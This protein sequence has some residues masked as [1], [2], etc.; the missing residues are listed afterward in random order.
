MKPQEKYKT[1]QI[2]DLTFTANTGLRLPPNLSLLATMNTSDQ[3]V[4]TLDN[5][6]QRRWEMELV[7]NKFGTGDEGENQKNAKIEGTKITWE[8]FQT[9]IN[10]LISDLSKDSG[11]SSMVDKRLGCWFV[12]AEEVNGEFIITQETF[13][14]KILKYLWDD[15]FKFNRDVFSDKN[16]D[17]FG[18]FEKLLEKVDF[19]KENFDVFKDIKFETDDTTVISLDTAVT[20]SEQ[21]V[22]SS[23]VEP[24]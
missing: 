18:D 4:F 21:N 24:I 7:E 5:A 14:N 3:N 19:A 2:G 22:I 11:F 8:N 15:A 1:V 9:K 6:F 10:T 16:G 17:E 13:K 12:K 20:S 23:A